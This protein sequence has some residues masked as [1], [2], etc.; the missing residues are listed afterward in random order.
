MKSISILLVV[1]LLSNTSYGQEEEKI[2]GFFYKISA[3]GT[4]AV[5]EHY[6]IQTDDDESLIKLNG[7]FISNTFGLQIN[8]RVS[9]G[10]NAG[11]DF[12]ESQDLRFAPLFMSTHYSY[13]VD[14]A[15]YFIRAGIGRLLKL[16]KNFEDGS[17]YKLG[18]GIQFFDKNFRKSILVGLDF[19][20][21][22]FGYR[23]QEKLSSL[24]LFIEYRLF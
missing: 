17:L 9:I 22:R 14:D 19:S 13:I 8:E 5:N 11:M 15:N 18:T 4:L 16:G 2:R 20:R 7:L 10:L 24:S 6:T 1:I 3:A 21:K 12:Y 23:E